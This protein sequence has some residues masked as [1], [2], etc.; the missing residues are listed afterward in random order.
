[1]RCFAV[2]CCTVAA[3]IVAPI[4]HGQP[5]G[6]H[7][8]FAHNDYLKPQPFRAAYTE[9]VGYIEVDVFLHN[10]ELLVA[11]TRA[12]INPL[13]NIEGMYLR[14]LAE[15]IRLNRGQA[16]SDSSLTLHLMVDIKTD[17]LPTLRKLIEI[18]SM[19]PD[20]TDCRSLLVTVSGNMPPPLDWAWVP[21][22][23]HFDGRVGIAYNEEQLQRVPLI[24][25]SFRN[26]SS[27]NGKRKLRDDDRA[28]LVEAITAIHLLGKPARLWAS[29]DNPVAW[30]ELSRLG[31]DILNTDNVAGAV[32]HLGR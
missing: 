21:S 15:Q 13:R 31:L 9:R 2:I 29:P 28:R 1:M 14:P 17:A 4:S 19:Y 22:F 6:R 8:V 30:D 16:Y 12:E 3:F 5:K 11:H 27:W 25:A 18:L 26:Y 23:I 7:S 24:S 10:N 20:L 32:Q